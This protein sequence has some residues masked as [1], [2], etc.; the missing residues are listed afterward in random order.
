[1]AR[2]QSAF[3]GSDRQGRGR[4]LQALRQGGVRAGELA[5]ACGWPDD[6]ARAERVAAALVDEG[7]AR[8]R[9]GPEPVLRL[10]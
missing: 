8:W 1:V 5:A 9:A 6:R 7:F 3:A 10:C 4:L 2:R